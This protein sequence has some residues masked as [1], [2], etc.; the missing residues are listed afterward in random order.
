MVDSF[1]FHCAESTDKRPTQAVFPDDSI[2]LDIHLK[3]TPE[4]GTYVFT[5]PIYM[6]GENEKD[7]KVLFRPGAMSREEIINIIIR[8][9]WEP[10]ERG[11]RGEMKPDLEAFKA[12]I[13]SEVGAALR[14]HPEIQPRST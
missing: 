3:G 1:R 4:N 13:T 12:R 9:F 14:K 8:A 6:T 2:R 7:K 10:L 5:A 11:K